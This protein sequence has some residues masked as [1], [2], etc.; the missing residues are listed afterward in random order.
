MPSWSSVQSK[1]R[2]STALHFFRAFRVITSLSNGHGAWGMGTTV[3][4]EVS[5][6]FNSVSF[7]RY[8]KNGLRKRKGKEL[9]GFFQRWIPLVQNAVIW[10]QSM[11][12]ASMCGSVRSFSK[13]RMMRICASLS[14]FFTG[15]FQI[16]TF[17]KTAKKERF[18]QDRQGSSTQ[19]ALMVSD[20][21]LH[22]FTLYWQPIPLLSRKNTFVITEIVWEMQ[23]RGRT[24]T[25][26]RSQTLK[27]PMPTLFWESYSLSGR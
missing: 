1:P 6:F 13:E 27:S 3:I 20:Y 14:S 22:I 25:W 2:F 12:A 19:P 18:W 11:T 16:E 23:S 15:R 7:D 4:I 24:S 9:G 10:R 17:N 5:S 21:H 8:Q 26:T